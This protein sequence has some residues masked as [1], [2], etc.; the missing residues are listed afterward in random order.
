[1]AVPFRNSIQ[2]H[3]PLRK[4]AAKEATKRAAETGG[5]GGSYGLI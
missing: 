1:M 2:E 5:S 4:P 3:R